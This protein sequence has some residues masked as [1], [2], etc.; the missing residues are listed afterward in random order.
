MAITDVQSSAADFMNW[1]IPYYLNGTVTAQQFYPYVI[2]NPIAV[3]EQLFFVTIPV[4][5]V[6]SVQVI[7][8][9]TSLTQSQ[10]LKFSEKAIETTTSSTTEGYK[11]GSGI[12]S[13]SK[14]SYTT[15]IFGSSIGLEQTFTVNVNSEYN[16][17]ST[18]TT[19]QT[20]ERLWKVTQPVS[21]LPYTRIVATLT[22][23]GGEVEIPMTLNANL[24]GQGLDTEYYCGA[25]FSSPDYPNAWQP[26]M[27]SNLY[28]TSWPNKPASFAGGNGNELILK[29]ASITT[30]GP[31]LYSTVHFEQTPLP[32]YERLSEPKSWYSN[33][34]VL[35]DGTMIT[36]PDLD[37]ATGRVLPSK[38]PEPILASS[39]IND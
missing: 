38:M 2:K 30:N 22:I 12:T 28:D 10:T 24:L 15:K 8:N 16:H 20:T 7:E 34:V 35:R 37:P 13:T 19:T 26:F 39:R 25:D 17:S 27:A 33:E 31:S 1:A 29:G 4:Q 3:P 5:K 18:E 11:V 6:A 36:I 23:M 32:G 21:V 14:F 9:N